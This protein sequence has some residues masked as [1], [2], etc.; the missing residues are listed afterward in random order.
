MIYFH[1]YSKHLKD[2][3]TG[4]NTDKYNGLLELAITLSHS[5]M[6]KTL[7]R[8][9]AASLSLPEHPIIKDE[10]KMKQIFKLLNYLYEDNP[11]M[12]AEKPSELTADLIKYGKKIIFL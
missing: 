7:Q 8:I 2:I 9:Y 11:K 3:E 5:N 6:P 12:Y 10:A 1:R 4:K